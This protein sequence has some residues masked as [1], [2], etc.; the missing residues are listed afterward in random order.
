MYGVVLA[1]KESYKLTWLTHGIHDIQIQV[2][3]LI[4]E[5]TASCLF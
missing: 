5:H 2:T 3:S 1:T 4:V